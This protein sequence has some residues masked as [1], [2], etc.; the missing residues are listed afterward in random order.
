M[1]TRQVLTPVT[2]TGDHVEIHES[3]SWRRKLSRFLIASCTQRLG[4]GRPSA[5]CRLSVVLGACNPFPRLT[6]GA[7][8][9]GHVNLGTV[10]VAYPELVPAELPGTICDSWDGFLWAVP[11]KRT[12]HSRKRKRMTN[13][14]LK[15]IRN[16]TVCPKCQNLKLLHVLCGHCLK[17]TLKRTAELRRTLAQQKGQ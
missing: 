9:E 15:P 12:S 16:Y 2:G 17:D 4:A 1:G 5:Y 6:N 13:K 11:K 8:L 3:M 10:Q 14:Y 7:D